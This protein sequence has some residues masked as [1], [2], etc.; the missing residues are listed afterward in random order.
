MSLA[1]RAP[2]YFLDSKHYSEVETLFRLE[3]PSILKPKISRERTR[4]TFQALFGCLMG[5]GEGGATKWSVWAT[6]LRH[7]PMCRRGYGLTVYTLRIGSNGQLTNLYRFIGH[8]DSRRSGL[9]SR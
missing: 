4:R 5:K 8:G 6:E 1:A 3:Q 9:T 2:R 7:A